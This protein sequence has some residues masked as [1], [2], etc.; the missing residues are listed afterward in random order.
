MLVLIFNYLIPTGATLL[1][2]QSRAQT[3]KAVDNIQRQDPD[4]GRE[5]VGVL[6]LQR[7]VM[8]GGSRHK[9]R[10][11]S[12]KIFS[13]LALSESQERRRLYRKDTNGDGFV[14]ILVPSGGGRRTACRVW[15]GKMMQ[16]PK[17]PAYSKCSGYECYLVAKGEAESTERQAG[18]PLPSRLA[19]FRRDT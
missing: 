9:N 16:H 5:S 19:S 1:S 10:I 14:D 12:R 11:S 2:A 6:L 8:Y 4:N 3:S 13:G 15:E 7:H 18:R 17:R